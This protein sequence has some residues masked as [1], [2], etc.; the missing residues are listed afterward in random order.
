[1]DRINN[2]KQELSEY[3]VIK[4]LGKV[5]R[6]L[7]MEFNQTE[8]VIEI[9]QRIYIKEVLK[10]FDMLNSKPVSTP[11]SLGIK[12]TRSEQGSKKEQNQLPFRELIGAL[13]YLAVATRPN[14]SFAVNWLSQFNNCYTRDHWIVAK[15]V[16]RYLRGTVNLGLKYQRTGSPLKGFV[17]ADWANCVNDRRSYTGY[18]FIFGNAAIS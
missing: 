5:K 2:F 14:I 16:L 1:M 17:D 13:M 6:Y 11:I 12:L 15:Q 9:S 7:G 8:D 3:F 18:V 4:D 10:K